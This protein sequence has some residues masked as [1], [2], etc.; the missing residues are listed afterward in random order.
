MK[1]VGHTLDSN[2]KLNLEIKSFHNW[3]NRTFNIEKLS[4]K[5]ENYYELDFEEFLKEIKK[6]KVDIS[7][8]KTQELLENE[9]NESISIIKPLQKEIQQLEKEIDNIIYELYDLTP[10]EINIIEDSLK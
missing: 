9:F 1:I 7:K 4:K 10:D 2:K 5:L 6:K 8:R 3:I